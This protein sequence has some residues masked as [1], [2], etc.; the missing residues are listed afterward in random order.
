MYST[1]TYKQSYTLKKEVQGKL[2]VQFELW[3]DLKKEKI[4]FSVAAGVGR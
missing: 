3:T 4:P 1:Y 2:V